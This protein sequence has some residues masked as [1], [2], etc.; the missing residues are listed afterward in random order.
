M[1]NAEHITDTNSFRRQV[2]LTLKKKKIRTKSFVLFRKKMFS[3][4]YGNQIV[5][6]KIIQ[7][8]QNLL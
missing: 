5:A 4:T 1:C 7:D 8:N 2:T 6:K 3:L